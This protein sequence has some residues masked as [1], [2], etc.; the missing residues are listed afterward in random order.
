MVSALQAAWSAIV[1]SDGFAET[2]STAIRIGDDTDTVAAIAGAL[3][4]AKRGASAIPAKWR[5]IL[6][7]YPASAV[8]ISCTP[9]FR[10]PP[11]VRNPVCGRM[12]RG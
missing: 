9:P 10:R 3:I 1:H 2:L 5:R 7:G 6:H 11:A 12:R 4:G 8:R